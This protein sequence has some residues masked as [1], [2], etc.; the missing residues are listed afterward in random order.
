LGWWPTLPGA[1]QQ[2]PVARR[3]VSN[4]RSISGCNSVPRPGPGGTEIKPFSTR[5]S[6]VTRSRYHVW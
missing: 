1:P 6:S 2:G 4:A 5:G 3:E